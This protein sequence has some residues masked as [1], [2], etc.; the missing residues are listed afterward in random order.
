[1]KKIE[2]VNLFQNKLHGPN[3]EFFGDFSSLEVL[4]VRGNNFTFELPKNLG[5]NGKLMMLDVSINQLTG[6]VPRGLCK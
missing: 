2:L 6:L 4:Q 1:L 3:P 5:W